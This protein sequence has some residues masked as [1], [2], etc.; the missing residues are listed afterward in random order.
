MIGYLEGYYRDFPGLDSKHAYAYSDFELENEGARK[1]DQSI[2][3]LREQF[4]KES[5]KSERDKLVKAI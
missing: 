2:D 4:Y 5:Q 3:K 1:R